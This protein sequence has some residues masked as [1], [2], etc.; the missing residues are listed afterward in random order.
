[1]VSD[2]TYTSPIASFTYVKRL[3]PESSLRY[4]N[5]LIDRVNSKGELR[6]KYL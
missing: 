3:E 6:D 4:E 5:L 2:S 1:M